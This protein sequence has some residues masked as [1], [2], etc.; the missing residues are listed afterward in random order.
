MAHQNAQ[1]IL[2]GPKDDATGDIFCPL[3]KNQCSDRWALS[4][5]KSYELKTMKKFLPGLYIHQ[6][7]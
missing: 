3:A 5:S 1:L 7:H 2:A 6:N 4:T